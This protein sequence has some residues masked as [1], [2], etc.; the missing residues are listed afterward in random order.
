MPVILKILTWLIVSILAGVLYR[1]GGA[2]GYNTKVRDLGVPT[3]VTVYLLTLGLKASLW[4]FCGLVV[5]YFIAFGLLFGA[6]T[7]YWKKKGTNV[8]WWNWLFTGLGYSLA[9]LPIALYTGHWIGFGIRCAVL[10][11]LIVW[12]SETQGNVVWEEGG[13]GFLIIATLPLLLI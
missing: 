3:I 12:W 7:T 10:T 13:R 5:A 1:M 8:H 4:S 6:L 9:A 2:A 11:G